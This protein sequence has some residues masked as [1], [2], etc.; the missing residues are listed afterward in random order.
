M[1]RWGQKDDVSVY[2]IAARNPKAE[3]WTMGDLPE[4]M[5]LERG[6]QTLVRL[7]MRN[8]LT[9]AETPATVVGRATAA[10]RRAKRW[11]ESAGK[12]PSKKKR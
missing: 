7:K 4:L 10:A 6:G 11:S 3:G 2:N 1:Q 12:L 8:L 9:R 5:E